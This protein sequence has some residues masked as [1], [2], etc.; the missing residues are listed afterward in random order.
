[1]KTVHCIIVQ[2]CKFIKGDQ[3]IFLQTQIHFKV[4]VGC[5]ICSH[6]TAI[7]FKV[8]AACRLGY[9]CPSCTAQPCM[10]NNKFKHRVIDLVW[11][12]STVCIMHMFVRSILK[13][14]QSDLLFLDLVGQ[15]FPKLKTHW[16]NY[17]HS[18]SHFFLPPR[19]L[20]YMYIPAYEKHKINSQHP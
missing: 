1:M 5:G 3:Q 6:I 15:F 18:F 13:L 17:S 10:W 20:S 2:Y 12:K 7:L 11:L 19:D 4:Q 9:A 14:F 8:G 16:N